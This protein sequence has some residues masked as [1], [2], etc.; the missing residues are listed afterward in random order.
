M[1]FIVFREKL[2][3]PALTFTMS[4]IVM[5]KKAAICF[6]YSGWSFGVVVSF[7]VGPHHL[8]VFFRLFEYK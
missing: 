8:Y 4:D 5:P 7:D 3:R 1:L 6:G 2:L